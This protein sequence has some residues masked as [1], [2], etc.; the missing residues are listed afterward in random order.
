MSKPYSQRGE[1][2]TDTNQ[3]SE[4]PP[5][6]CSCCGVAN[7]D[8]FWDYIEHNKDTLTYDEVLRMTDDFDTYH[9]QWN[10]HAEAARDDIKAGRPRK[11]YTKSS[12][13]W[14]RL[15]ERDDE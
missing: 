2:G 14:D 4:Y 6:A 9:K 5:Y 15:K 10:A 1:K 11:K 13:Y 7:G 3:A 8:M 12:P